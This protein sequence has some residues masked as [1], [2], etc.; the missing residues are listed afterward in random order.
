MATEIWTPIK[1]FEGRYEISDL[2]RVRSL[3]FTEEN[4]GFN[5]G[6]YVKTGKVLSPMLDS[7]NHIYVALKVSKTTKRTRV[8]KLMTEAF[9]IELKKGQYLYCI[10][11]DPYNC[12]LSNLIAAYRGQSLV[13]VILNDGK[14]TCNTCRHRRSISDFPNDKNSPTG[15]GRRCNICSRSA[16]DKYY[17]EAKLD[18]IK[19]A[20]LKATRSPHGS[21]ASAFRRGVNKQVKK[22]E[23]YESISD[24]IK[25]IYKVARELERVDGSELHVDHIVPLKAVNSKGEHIATGLHVPWNLQILDATV[26]IKKKNKLAEV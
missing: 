23:I 13:D 25:D 22:W 3:S 5:G 1:G 2:G 12:A 6:M 20:K 16:A 19:Y 14:H 21:A 10:D 18:L 7:K 17:I 8:K 15:K 24:E 11:E 26:N 4:D 9:G